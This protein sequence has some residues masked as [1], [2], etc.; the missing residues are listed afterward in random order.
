MGIKIK[1]LISL[2][3][4]TKVFCKNQ[5]SHCLTLNEYKTM[6]RMCEQGYADTETIEC[7]K[8]NNE[9]KDKCVWAYL[10]SNNEIKCHACKNKNTYGEKCEKIIEIFTPSIKDCKY[11]NSEYANP[12]SKCVICENNLVINEYNND[13]HSNNSKLYPSSC[14]FN[15]GV[16]CYKSNNDNIY[17]N[18]AFDEITDLSIEDPSH[19]TGCLTQ[20]DSDCYS[21]LNKYMMNVKGE[22]VPIEEEKKSSNKNEKKVIK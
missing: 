18:K 20:N 2:L 4:L 11:Y 16:T 5:N 10:A 3:L 1:S 13:C 6:C 15:D 21:C 17:Y 19:V 12:L 14:V 8:N 22:C 9:W 7:V